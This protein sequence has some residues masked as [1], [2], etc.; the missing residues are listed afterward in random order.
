MGRMLRQKN[1]R[2][3]LS[4]YRVA[5]HIK[6]PYRVLCDGPFIQAASKLKLL[7]HLPARV[8]SQ[9]CNSAVEVQTTACVLAEMRALGGDIAETAARATR[10]LK[11]HRCGHA[12][13]AHTSG[14]ECVALCVGGQNRRKFF[15]GTQDGGLRDRLRAAPGPVPLLSLNRNSLVILE[16]RTM[17]ASADVQ[18]AERQKRAPAKWE[19]QQISALEGNRTAVKAVRARN[20]AKAAGRRANPL[21]VGELPDP[22]DYQK[23]G[24]KGSKGSRKRDRGRD[25]RRDDG[26]GHEASRIE[27]GE[28]AGQFPTPKKQR[29]PS[30]DYR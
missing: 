26:G 23:G 2:K 30:I 22:A 7:N 16:K 18:H 29:R 13:G 24:G 5:H 3:T 15:V 6:P 8:A 9:L 19:R 10:V 28:G 20:A 4:F 12:P 17:A 21:V 1:H 25:D 14:A 11:I 27:G